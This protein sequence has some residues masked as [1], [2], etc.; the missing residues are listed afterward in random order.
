MSTARAPYRPV[1]KEPYA[2]EYSSKNPLP[3]EKVGRSLKTPVLWE[4]S[5]CAAEWE[6]APFNRHMGNGK[7]PTC[8]KREKELILQQRAIAHQEAL[9]EK[10]RAR[11]REKEAKKLAHKAEVEKRR[12]ERLRTQG[13]ALDQYAPHLIPQIADLSANPQTI[14]AFSDKKLRWKCDQGHQWDASIRDRVRKNSGCPYCAGKRPSAGKT[15]LKTRY[16]ELAKELIDPHVSAEEL[17]FGSNKKV[18][19]K[20]TTCG[21]EWYATPNART[22]RGDGCPRCSMA[23]TSRLEDEVCEYVTSLLPPGE[24]IL[25]R[26]RTLLGGK[27]IDILIPHRKIAIEVNGLFWHSEGYHDRESHR[28]KYNAASRLGYRLVV[29]WEDDWNARRNAVESVLKGILS[30]PE[31]RPADCS[32]TVVPQEDAA[33]FYYK[34][35]LHGTPPQKSSALGLTYKNDL[36]MCMSLLRPNQ[37]DCEIV[38]VAS[39]EPVLS[40]LAKLLA[41]VIPDLVDDGVERI[42]AKI[43]DTSPLG[44]NLSQLGFLAEEIFLPDYTYINTSRAQQR[45]PKTI[46]RKPS[47]PEENQS[48]VYQE[49]MTERELAILNGFTRVWD[50]GKTRWVKRL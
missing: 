42:T 6:T 16:P 37:T 49:G 13:K 33:A 36:V 35:G 23:G 39:A 45:L 2:H 41:A 19:W 31:I 15:D 11:A 3:P 12:V 27:E 43:E 25:R 21:N 9:E 44:D 48:L 30:A 32:V 1:S 20:C 8:N 40:G 24:E 5:V 47:L 38:Q 17:S 18:L 22:Y 50:Y 28:E 46:L 14:S 4:C 7:C 10:K 26:N 34:W 29:V